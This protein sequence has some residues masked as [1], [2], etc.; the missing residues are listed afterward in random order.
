MRNR[1]NSA[2]YLHKNHGGDEMILYPIY[3][4]GENDFSLSVVEIPQPYATEQE[5]LSGSFEGLSEFLDRIPV[6]DEL[7][8]TA[9][10]RLSTEQYK[11]CT[12]KGA[13]DFYSQYQNDG[14]SER[15]SK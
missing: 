7:P 15:G 3:K 10:F 8:L 14:Y 9:L 12:L 13:E 4:Y 1:K 6:S 11:I 2:F 5:L